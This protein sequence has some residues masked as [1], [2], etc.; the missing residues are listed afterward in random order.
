MQTFCASL[1]TCASKRIYPGSTLGRGTTRTRTAVRNRTS[2]KLKNRWS[3]ST[4]HARG[5]WG[6]SAKV[7]GLSQILVSPVTRCQSPGIEE[8]AI[9]IMSHNELMLIA[10]AAS[11]ISDKAVPQSTF[12]AF[13]W[14]NE[15]SGDV[16]PPGSRHA[17]G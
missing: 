15:G 13:P 7:V 2:T 16:G 3:G 10:V 8:E 11:A 14:A 1:A 17:T 12:R 9:S 4:R 5:G 6:R